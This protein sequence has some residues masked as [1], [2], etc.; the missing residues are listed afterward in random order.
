MR[1]SVSGGWYYTSA[2][3]ASTG[4]RR[5]PKTPLLARNRAL[6]DQAL[7]NIGATQPPAHFDTL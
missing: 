6:A 4:R 7:G 1:V 2:S 5:T 3:A